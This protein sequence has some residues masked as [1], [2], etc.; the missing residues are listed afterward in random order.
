[1]GNLQSLIGLTNIFQDVELSTAVNQLRSDPVKLQQFLQSQQTQVY[2]DILRQKDGTFQKVYGDLQRAG[3]VQE[4]VLMHNK[5]SK[6]L[7]NI[8]QQVYDNQKN[9]A[10]AVLE[11]K[12][13]AGRKNEMNEWSVS[14]KNDT[15]FVFSS[16]FIMLSGLLL[17]TVLWRM[18]LIGAGLWVALGIPMIIIF[19]LIV[20][21]RSQYTDV[22]R[23]KRYWNKQIFEGK[24]GKIPIPMCPQITESIYSMGQSA[25][26]GMANLAQMGAQGMVAA[27]QT[28]ADGS[29]ALA[30]SL[31]PNAAANAGSA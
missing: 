5:R 6:E 3:K 30:N 18:S 7:T 9:S 10:S 15:L 23:N 2:T 14:N 22:L 21:N 31:Q 17:I 4:S 24:Y 28:I 20:V 1:M 26:Q 25:S 27:S 13:I 12:N 19:I 29:M 16:L 8:Q 11:D